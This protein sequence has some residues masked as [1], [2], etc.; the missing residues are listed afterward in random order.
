MADQ[1]ET[2]DREE[3]LR[4]TAGRGWEDADV[5][6]ASA[7]FGRIYLF[8]PPGVGKTRAAYHRGRIERGLYAVTLTQ[9]L[10][11][12]ELRGTYLPRGEAFEWHDGPVVRA[13]REGA[14]LVLNEIAH[15][16]EDALA[17][18]HPV[19]E[20]EDTARL[21]LPSGE[22]VAPAPGFHVVVTDNGPP[23]ALPPALR[24]R[25]DARIELPDPHPDAVASLSEPL[26]EPA[27]R[28]ALLD[29][30]RRVSLRA[31]H[32]LDRVRVEL[33]LER[34]CRIVFGAERGAEIFD[35]LV[36]AGVE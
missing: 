4:H 15:A 24:D 5:A 19:L 25:F 9:E 13:M 2:K 14:R 21:T 26:R 18:L 6:L 8:G 20:L 31:W 27:R 10:P 23:E 7:H 16:S 17:F 34:A 12:A 1:R 3:E 22:T 32:V 11:S 33:G 30:E 28:A 29:E 35:S 36:L